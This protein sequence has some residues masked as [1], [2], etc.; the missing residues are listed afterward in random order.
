M[1]EYLYPVKDA[2]SRPREVVARVDRVHLPGLHR[3]Q[4]LPARIA[5]QGASL[6]FRAVEVRA[7]RRN[8]EYLGRPR[9][10]VVP[11]D[12]Y[13]IGAFASERVSAAGQLDHLRY[14]MAAAEHWLDP[15]QEKDAPSAHTAQLGRQS[16]ESLLLC[17]D[18]RFG[19]SRSAG[20]GRE[21]AQV[22]IDLTERTRSERQHGG[23]PRQGREC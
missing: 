17:L 14:P 21:R 12:A 8:D 23:F 11:G 20:R 10:D 18:E 6:L 16:G 3:R 9:D 13:G 2:R 15:L 1:R 4:W 7:A 5:E 19:N 22:L